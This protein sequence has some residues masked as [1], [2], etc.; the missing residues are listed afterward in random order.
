MP[1]AAR[2]ADP[3]PARA[4]SLRRALLKYGDRPLV[5]ELLEDLENNPEAAAALAGADPREPLKALQKL[6]ATPGGAALAAKYMTRP[7]LIALLAEMRKDPEL[8]PLFG[9]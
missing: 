8:A 7:D 2:P 4:E 1:E 6:R 9:R 5:K 3:A